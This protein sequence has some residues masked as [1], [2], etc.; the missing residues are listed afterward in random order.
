MSQ[1]KIKLITEDG[2]EVEASAPVILSVSRATDIPAF[3]SEWFFNRLDKR[4]CKWRNPFNGVDSYVSFQNVRFIVFWSKNPA[5][6]IPFLIKLR[7]R[8][9][10]CYIQYT[11]NDYEAENLEPGV[12]S[13]EYRIE[14][15]RQLFN[16]LGPDGV[17][18]RFDPMM[19]CENIPIQDLLG[20]VE[21]IADKL[22]GLTRKLVFSYADISSYRKV[23]HN[24]KKH[25]VRYREWTESDMMEFAEQLVALNKRKKWN[26]QLA[27]CGEKINLEEFGI[28]HN[29]CID[30]ELITRI[31]WRDNDLMDNL[32]MK[33][34]PFSRN[35]FGETNVPKDAIVINDRLYAVRTRSNRDSGQRKLCGCI[36]AK[37][38]GQ[39]NTCPHGCVYCYANTSPESP[40]HRAAAHDKEHDLLIC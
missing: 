31:A 5:P 10:G 35:L 19:L 23:E 34:K 22:M 14:T 25:S 6:L 3:Y 8:G 32:G 26:L 12:P 36:S 21:G 17:I 37:D 40:G 13:L 2:K 38:I 15:F 16:V 28:E 4:Y 20:K 1:K 24:L 18:W 30:D 27:T 7:D 9:I 29:R 11:L 33:I 39:Y